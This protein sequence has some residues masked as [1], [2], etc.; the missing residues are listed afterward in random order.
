MLRKMTKKKCVT[1]KLNLSK[2]NNNNKKKREVV[3]I[4][5]IL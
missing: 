5:S 3:I 4:I 2:H 1:N